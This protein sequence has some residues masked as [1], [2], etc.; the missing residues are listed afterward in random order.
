MYIIIAIQGQCTS[1]YMLHVTCDNN[2]CKSDIFVQICMFHTFPK[3]VWPSHS[4]YVLKP[5][6]GLLIIRQAAK[7][8]VARSGWFWWFLR[9]FEPQLGRP[10]PRKFNGWN[11]IPWRFGSDHFPF[12]KLGDGCRFQPL[13]FQ[14]VV[15][16]SY[17]SFREVFFYQSWR[18]S[19]N[20][21]ANDFYVWWIHGTANFEFHRWKTCTKKQKT[22]AW[23]AKMKVWLC[24]VQ[25]CSDYVPL[26][27]GGDFR[28]QPLVFRWR[29]G[30]V[31]MRKQQGSD[32]NTFRP[33]DLRSP[34][35]PTI[36][37]CR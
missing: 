34:R 37:F 29:K 25:I 6:W 8:E 30:N 21:S 15:S 35:F 18:S 14:G 32:L 31:D 19:E 12:S 7:V 13:I 10:T 23:K 9:L 27:F 11:I 28:F 3:I 20:I 4:R 26:H 36:E 16:G 1:M 33:R 17:G 5:L 2:A 24:L 22:N